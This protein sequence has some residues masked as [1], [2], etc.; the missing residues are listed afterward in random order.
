[1]TG[2]ES[3]VLFL[4]QRLYEESNLL[5]SLFK[6]AAIERSRYLLQLSMS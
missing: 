1:M 2:R 6:V 3:V 5:R 4:A